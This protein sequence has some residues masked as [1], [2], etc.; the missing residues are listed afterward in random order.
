[1]PAGVATQGPETLDTF[2]VTRSCCEPP[3][4][5][6]NLFSASTKAIVTPVERASTQQL[7]PALDVQT[8]VQTAAAVHALLSPAHLL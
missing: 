7:G 2:R 1:M 5:C 4:P 8:A 6:T 3:F